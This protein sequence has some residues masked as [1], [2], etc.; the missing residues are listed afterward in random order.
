MGRFKR[1]WKATLITIYSRMRI[2][3]VA[4]QFVL[5]GFFDLIN[6]LTMLVFACLKLE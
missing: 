4:H 5:T 6:V 3:T 1:T 2:L